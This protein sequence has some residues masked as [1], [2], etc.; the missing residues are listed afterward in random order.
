MPD[1]SG[2]KNYIAMLK[3]GETMPD[4]SGIKMPDG[5]IQMSVV[6]LN[7][8]LKTLLDIELKMGIQKIFLWI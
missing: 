6:A 2:I 8:S 5:Q 7:L 1:K 3:I 4:K